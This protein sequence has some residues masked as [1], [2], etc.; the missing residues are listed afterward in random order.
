MYGIE[1]Y[2]GFILAGVLLNL[3]PGADTMFILTRSIS[4]GNRAG[5][6]SVLGISTGGLVHTV[7]ASLGLSIILAKS[8]FLFNTVKYIG[9]AY[10]V[11][12]G[13][14]MI[15]EKNNLFD[16]KNQKIEKQKL[17]KIYRQGVFTN[18]LN[19]KVALFFISFLPQFINPVYVK[20]PLPFLI[21]GLTFVTTMTLWYFILAYFSSFITQ[22]LRNNDK[23]GKIMQKVS[24]FIFIGLGVKI[25]LDK[26]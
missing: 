13:I 3:T 15:V 4:Q 21:L 24:G 6:Y 14:K 5:I 18:T 16:N 20:G 2:W 10:L 23:V 1:N 8:A 22:A 7:F 11:Y 17:F 25:V 19:P 12:L 9:V 26:H